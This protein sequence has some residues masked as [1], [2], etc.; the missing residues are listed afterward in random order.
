MKL[1]LKISLL[2]ALLSL[3]SLAST[4][5]MAAD[6]PAEMSTCISDLTRKL[7]QLTDEVASAKKLQMH[8][9]R[10]AV[11]RLQRL[12]EETS[13][14]SKTPTHSSLKNCKADLEYVRRAYDNLGAD[15]NFEKCMQPVTQFAV[16]TLVSDILTGTRNKSLTPEKKAE[17]KKLNDE[18]DTYS[19]EMAS[20]RF[21]STTQC[22]DMDKKLHALQAKIAPY[23]K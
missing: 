22:H 19:K 4:Q 8:H 14:R 21:E 17:M 20:S 12:D 7:G 18:Y 5:A 1:S 11:A 6:N 2:G 3:F 15:I 9:N 23:L 10:A 16:S 13:K